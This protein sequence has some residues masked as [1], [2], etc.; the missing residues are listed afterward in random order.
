MNGI[1]WIEYV[2]IGRFSVNPVIYTLYFLFTEF[3]VRHLGTLIYVI[4]Q[5]S[6]A[7]ITDTLQHDSHFGMNDY[8]VFYEMSHGISHPNLVLSK[9]ATISGHIFEYAVENLHYIPW[10][11]HSSTI[12]PHTYTTHNCVHGHATAFRLVAQAPVKCLTGALLQIFC[13]CV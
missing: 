1:V 5:T 13:E 11:N 8:Y 10:F 4:S 6:F 3:F 2:Y 9:R 12:Y 7:I